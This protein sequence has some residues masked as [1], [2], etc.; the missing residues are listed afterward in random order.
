MILGLDICAD[1][2][3]LH[4]HNHDDVITTHTQIQPHSQHT[5]PPKVPAGRSSDETANPPKL[6]DRWE[7]HEARGRV[8]RPTIVG[9]YIGLELDLVYKT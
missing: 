6:G 5:H 1:S 8:A 7:D 2:R 3:L 4:A 9:I